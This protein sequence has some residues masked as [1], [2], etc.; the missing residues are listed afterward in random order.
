MTADAYHLTSPDPEGDGA[1]RSMLM[2]V[3]DAG[4]EPEDVDYINAHG[5]STDY[6]DKFET[7]AI[8]GAFGEH[9]T[10]ALARPNP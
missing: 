2:A 1:K 8:K 4:L 10:F 7:M 9:H 5:T 3:K 6:N